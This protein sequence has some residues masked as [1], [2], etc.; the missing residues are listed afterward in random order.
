MLALVRMLRAAAPITFP[1][2]T[3]HELSR[4]K[5]KHQPPA[6]RARDPTVGARATLR[7]RR[8]HAPAP[9]RARPDQSDGAS[10]K[11]MS[12]PT[13]RAANCCAKRRSSRPQQLEPLSG[14]PTCQSAPHLCARQTS[15]CRLVVWRRRAAT[16]RSPVQLRHPLAIGSAR[17]RRWRRHHA[18]HHV[19]HIVLNICNQSLNIHKLRDGRCPTP[20]ARWPAPSRPRTQ[21]SRARCAWRALLAC[22]TIALCAL[23]I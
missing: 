16:A 4:A 6:L 17:A 10:I 12:A 9:L 13:S 18:P 5:L 1:L 22:T 3:H 15:S 2:R 20:D 7:A 19:R 23:Q 21:T 11:L 14:P 8:R